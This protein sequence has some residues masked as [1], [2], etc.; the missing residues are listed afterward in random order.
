MKKIF[1]VVLCALLISCGNNI[2]KEPIY[3]TKVVVIEPETALYAPVTKPTPPDRDSYIA[4]PIEDRE[5]ILVEYLNKV[6]LALNLA[7]ERFKLI[8]KNIDDKKKL[9]DKGEANED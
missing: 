5:N 1:L 2:V 7:N 8:A 3:V 9:I 6:M 4:S